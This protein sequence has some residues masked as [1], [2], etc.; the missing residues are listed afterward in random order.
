MGGIPGF[1]QS[2]RNGLR[3]N[4]HFTLKTNPLKEGDLQ[5]FVACYQGRDASPQA[6]AKG[7]KAAAKKTDRSESGPCLPRKETDRF[8]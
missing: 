5:D 3:T 8:K 2:R 4:Q 1:L 6:S 7:R